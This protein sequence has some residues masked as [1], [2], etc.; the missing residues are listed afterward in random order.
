M[1]HARLGPSNPRWVFCPGSVREEANYPDSPPGAAAVDGTGT[2]LLLEGC[3]VHDIDD[4][5]VYDRQRIG[6]GHEDNPHGWLVDRDRITRVNQCLDYIKA[7]VL[8]LKAEYLG[9]EVTVQS[10]SKSDPGA[11]YG[12]DDWWG[13]CDVIVTLKVRG[14]VKFMEV[15][16]YKDGRMMVGAKDNSQLLSYLA[17]SLWQEGITMAH[18]VRMTIVQPKTK[19]PVRHQESTLDEVLEESRILAMHAIATDD[20]DA[21]LHKG[22]HC[23]WCKH[24]ANCNA[25]DVKSKEV[26]AT[27]ENT[28]L[29][30]QVYG[31][32]TAVTN[33]SLSSIL[34]AEE[35]F[36]EGFKIA[37][38]ETMK[39]IGNGIEV[40]G[41]AM[42]PGRGSRKW[43]EADED[44]AKK[45]KGMKLKKDEIYPAKLITPAAAEKL[46]QFTDKQLKNLQ[47]M[48]AS[49][50]GKPTL[51]KSF[52]PE[53][54]TAEQ[55]FGT[56]PA[57]EQDSFL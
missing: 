13:T 56:D 53:A 28:G 14:I 26:I 38:N 33:E 9:G 31:D 3:L 10:E 41:Y 42:L 46:E 19:P 39:R 1:A 2:H 29:I 52:A 34:D 22:K 55:L 11:M 7:R 45:L 54:P 49:V 32:L 44:I 51:K 57:I 24:K 20:P 48:I 36:M 12:R 30:E 27:M 8:A 4:A 43:N 50:E 23:R 37:R 17:G 35:R 21:P 16:D 47:G 25:E 5:K 15:I 18:P 40:P 6:E